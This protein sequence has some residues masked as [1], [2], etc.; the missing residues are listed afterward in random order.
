MI[1]EV[2]WTKNMIFI[3]LLWSIQCKER[4][5]HLVDAS[6]SGER[7]DAPNVGCLTAA[8]HERPPAVVKTGRP[9]L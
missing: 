5:S 3:Q 9:L 6:T 4:K 7:A 1:Y 8:A 2:Y